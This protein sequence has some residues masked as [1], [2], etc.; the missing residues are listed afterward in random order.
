MSCQCLLIVIWQDFVQ[1]SM[2]APTPLSGTGRH[3]LLAAT[4]A[5]PSGTLPDHDQSR[6]YGHVK[7]KNEIVQQCCC[8]T[9]L[10][11]GWPTS[12]RG[13]TAWRQ[14]TGRPTGRAA[15][16]RTLRPGLRCPARCTVAPQNTSGQWKNCLPQSI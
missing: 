12:R 10:P 9:G 7:A 13:S 11:V 16:L 14:Q 8:A 4:R 5:D 1:G 3:Q 15:A 2:P 6:S